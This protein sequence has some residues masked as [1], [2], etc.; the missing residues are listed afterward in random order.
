MFAVKKFAPLLALLLLS[1]GK[2]DIEDENL[3]KGKVTFYNE[4]RYEVSVNESSFDGRTLVEKL[5]P[6]SSLS[7]MLNPSDN[8]G[9]GTAFSMVY[10]YR[11]ISDAEYACGDVWIN[12]IDPNMQITQNIIG[13]KSYVIQIP[14]PEKL[15]F[16]GSFIKISNFSNMPIEFN[17][18]SLFFKQAGNK[19]LSVPSGKTGIY[20]VSDNDYYGETEIKDYTITQV[21]ETYPF[22]DFTAKN[23]YIYNFEFDGNTVTPKEE[24][25]LT[26]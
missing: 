18:L 22:P 24:Q 9:V 21:F 13:G 23:G 3:Q 2:H 14:P 19:E 16:L 12:G 5:A 11:V 8:Y 20:K 26:F 15:D 17:H 25:K 6:G 1:C 4:S 10:W 7:V